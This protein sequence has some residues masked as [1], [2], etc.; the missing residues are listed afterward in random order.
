VGIGTTIP[1]YSLD[2]RG[3]INLTGTLTNSGA[4]VYP[5]TDEDETITGTWEFDGEI[6]VYQSGAPTSSRRMTITPS[7]IRGDKFISTSIYARGN[8]NNEGLILG[9]SKPGSSDKPMIKAHLNGNVGIGDPPPNSPSYALDV[10]GTAAANTLRLGDYTVEQDSTDG[11]LNFFHSGTKVLEVSDDGVLRAKSDVVAFALS[12]GS[13]GSS[14][15]GFSIAGEGLESPDGE[16]LNVDYGTGLTVNNGTLEATGT[17]NVQALTDLSDVGTT[18]GG[19][20]EVLIG[21]GTNYDSTPLST[22]AGNHL[23]LSDLS[24]TQYSSLSGTPSIAYNSTIPADNFTATEV[25]ALRQDELAS[26]ATPWTGNNF[27]SD[28]DARSAINT[29]SDHGSTASHNYTTASDLDGTG[30]TASGGQLD[31]NEGGIQ[32]DNLSGGTDA[33]AHHAVFEPSD[34][35]PEADTHTRPSTGD[36]LTGTTTFKV[37][38]TVARTNAS[39]VFEDQIRIDGPLAGSDNEIGVGNNDYVLA[40]GGRP[41]GV[42]DSDN[43]G[44]DRLGSGLLQTA[45]GGASDYRT[46]LQGGHGR[47]AHTWN[48]YYDSNASTWRSVVDNEPHTLVG[49][50]NT[51]PG[52]VNGGGVTLAAADAVNT[53]NFDNEQDAEDPIDWNVGLHVDVDGSVI[54][55]GTDS[56]S[57]YTLNVDGS[58]DLVITTPTGNKAKI[59]SNGDIEAFA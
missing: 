42:D 44:D 37:D 46:Y 16:T 59:L 39:S 35:N 32:H 30:L 51:T 50:G 27:Y 11:D 58:G 8:N 20:G 1:S 7:E 4:A 40:L 2:V 5:R 56:S 21:D 31:V 43:T 49:I 23:R 6:S 19:D 13:T 9:N 28:S 48:A 22:A 57:G 33:D 10:N 34:Y 54:V 18:G 15:G 24:S 25:T 14:G 3:D 52:N 17:S 53:A 38:S 45:H 36:G 55:Q 41:Y 12:G 26:G 47:V 29:D